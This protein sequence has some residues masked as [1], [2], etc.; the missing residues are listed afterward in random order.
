MNS[1]EAR[2]QL[3]WSIFRLE[4]LLSIMSGRV[5]SLGIAFASLSPPFLNP[6]MDFT[7]SD[8]KQPNNELQ[9]S[10]DLDEGK[11]ISQTSFLKSLE[12]SHRLYCF[13]LIDLALITHTIT[14][15][16]FCFKPSRMG[17]SCFESRIA[18]YRKKLDFW[19]S[20]IHTSFGF[21]DGQIVETSKGSPYQ[22]S[23]ALNYYS[24]H[25]L[26]NRPCLNG[27]AFQEKYGLRFANKMAFD[28]LQASLNAIAQLP[29]LPDLT[30]CF[31]V[32]QW[33]EIL[34]V[35]TQSI[36]ILLLDISVG[37]V[38]AST[39]NIHLPAE[40]VVWAAVTKGLRWLHCL[41]RTSESAR[42]GFRFFNACVQRM[43]PNRTLEFEG[44]SSVID[45]PR[46]PS[47]PESLELQDMLEPNTVSF[48]EEYGGVGCMGPLKRNVS[49]NDGKNVVMC[50]NLSEVHSPSVSGA[51]AV[52]DTGETV[53]DLVSNPD[54]AVNDILFSMVRSIS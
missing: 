20:T 26:L 53:L 22:L 17:W 10:I 40:S 27:P 47:G 24:T 18:F 36:T 31:Q 49:T 34:H 52:L 43:D 28:C 3:W 15:E 32:P 1:G 51:L 37:P 44:T 46:A 54:F 19:A 2:K 38:S 7:V 41:G 50:Q 9:W 6:N 42:R 8:A 33:W 16:V 25:I 39:M 23:L 45:P 5:A 35:L 14:N 21:Q 48:S 4:S 13:Y 29:D 11:A 30:W 12:P